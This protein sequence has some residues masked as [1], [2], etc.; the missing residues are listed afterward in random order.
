MLTLYRRLIDLRR[1]QPALEI[2]R[3]RPV[4]ADCNLLAYLR[5]ARAGEG[6]YLIALN[7]GTGDERVMAPTDFPGGIVAVSTHLD[8]EGEGVDREVHLRPNEGVVVRIAAA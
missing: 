7:L 6:D 1:G 4:V 8:R 2:G 5:L 3:Y